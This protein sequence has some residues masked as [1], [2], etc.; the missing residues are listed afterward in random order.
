MFVVVSFRTGPGRTEEVFKDEKENATPVAY[1]FENETG[2]KDPDGSGQ[3]GSKRLDQNVGRNGD[4]SE[5]RAPTS[6]A[7][8]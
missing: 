8:T 6:W 3:S 2:T 4:A 7:T 5:I 1:L